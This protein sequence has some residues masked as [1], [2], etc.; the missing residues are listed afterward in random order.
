[1]SAFNDP[2]TPAY[3][4]LTGSFYLGIAVFGA[5]AI[6]YVPSQIVTGDAAATLAA[7]NE[8]RGLFNAGVG[9]DAVVMGF[10]VMATTMLY[11]I[12][13]RVN[14]TLA[15]AATLARFGMVA[16]M[17]T[18]LLF[19]AGL[20]GLA[21]GSIPAGDM[22]EPM[23]ELLLHVHHSGVWAWQILFGV[24]LILLGTLVMRSGLFPRLL[25]MGMV[26]GAFGYLADSAYAFAFPGADWLGMV[27]IG[28]LVIVTLSE[29]GFALWLVT[30][31]PRRVSLPAV[32]LV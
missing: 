11:Q 18:M 8:K 24:H 13:R 4:R 19:Q 16:I 5:F 7:I 15:F 26:I 3:A 28:L 23:A 22:R 17:G 30:K 2:T 31:G 12:F 32:G 14:E 20:A 10:E 9:A 1:M 25:G 29:V 21:D 27:R 6:G